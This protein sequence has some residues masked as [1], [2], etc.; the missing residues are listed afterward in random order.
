MI[1]KL[2]AEQLRTI[3]YQALNGRDNFNNSLNTPGQKFI[4][5]FSMSC[6]TKI[7]EN[8]SNLSIQ[9]WKHIIF[10]SICEIS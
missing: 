4:D 10:L 1:S 7:T 8:I 5:F 9:E 3:R 2:N 6:Y